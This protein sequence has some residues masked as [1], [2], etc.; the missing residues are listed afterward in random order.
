MPRPELYLVQLLVAQSCPTLCDPIHCS[1]PGSSVHGLLQARIVEWVPFPFFR[2]YSQLREWTWVSCIAGRFFTMWAT[3][4]YRYKWCVLFLLYFSSNLFSMFT[5]WLLRLADPWCNVVGH[6][7]LC[8]IVSL[9]TFME[10]VWKSRWLKIR[11]CYCV[12][13]IMCVSWNLKSR[14]I[15][16]MLWLVRNSPTVWFLQHSLNKAGN[17]SGICFPWNSK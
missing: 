5:T 7:F 8:G 1:P 10:L 3:R 2:R 4:E 6:H 14:I 17:L 11:W 12:I 13:I 16:W 15:S 9:S